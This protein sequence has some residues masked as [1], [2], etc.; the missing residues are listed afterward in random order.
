VPPNEPLSPRE[1]A[2]RDMICE[3]LTDKQIAVRLSISHNT[4]RVHRAAV[5]RKYGVR[6]VAAVCSLDALNKET[7]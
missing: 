5:R 1:T 2:V 7:A 4:V 6:N 3:G